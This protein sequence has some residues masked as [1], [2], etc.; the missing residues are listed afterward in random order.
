[1]RCVRL[2]IE[3]IGDHRDI[4]AFSGMRDGVVLRELC[5]PICKECSG[6]S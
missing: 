5:I 1:M 6:A 2:L 3:S 4:G